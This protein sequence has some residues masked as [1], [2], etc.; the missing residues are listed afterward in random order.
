MQKL[1]VQE[2]GRRSISPALAVLSRQTVYSY[3][4]IE[5]LGGKE[6]QGDLFEQSDTETNSMKRKKVVQAGLSW[7]SANLYQFCLIL[8]E[9]K[10]N[11]C[12]L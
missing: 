8:V 9:D 1:A 12:I 6:L 11:E 5:K 3:N 4:I 10:V 2:R 7:F